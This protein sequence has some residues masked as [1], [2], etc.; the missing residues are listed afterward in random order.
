MNLTFFVYPTNNIKV[1]DIND[2][3]VEEV[4]RCH[5]VS[6]QIQE[7]NIQLNCYA[8]PLKG[9]NMVLGEKLLMKLC[10]NTK[11]L[12]VHYMEF[13]WKGSNHRSHILR[14]SPLKQN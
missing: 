10:S 4:R 9:V 12:Q 13:I 3:H 2:W 11:N 14:I 5:N 6:L 7:L 8:L 1:L